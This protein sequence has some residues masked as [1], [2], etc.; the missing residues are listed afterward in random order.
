MTGLTHDHKV[1]RW[2]GVR[3]I[4]PE[5]IIDARSRPR[6]RAF[7][8]DRTSTHLPGTLGDVAARGWT[9]T[10]AMREYAVRLFS[11]DES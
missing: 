9:T 5:R 11:P 7:I 10:P 2:R 4:M 8:E 1:G 6:I 3:D